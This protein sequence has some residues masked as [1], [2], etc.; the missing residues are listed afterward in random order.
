M[1][2]QCSPNQQSPLVIPVIIYPQL[3][4][5]QMQNWR[6]RGRGRAG[7]YDPYFISSQACFNCG[8][9]GHF[10]CDCNIPGWNPRGNY[11]RGFRGQLRPFGGPMNPHR[12][13]E[14]GFQRCPEDLKG[15][16][17]RAGKKSNNWGQ[18]QSQ[19]GTDPH[20]WAWT[21][22]D[23]PEKE[24]RETGFALTHRCITT[25]RKEVM[26]WQHTF[27][28]YIYSKEVICSTFKIELLLCE[29]I[30]MKG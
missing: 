5:G 20:R 16:V 28:K 18:G 14:P 8:Q 29:N 15:G 2:N 11:R 7:R 22:A 21:S 10:A 1:Q 23:W 13:L 30:Y 25:N 3:A 6:G 9:D 4:S 26:H 17:I 24:G 12:S 27:W 19:V